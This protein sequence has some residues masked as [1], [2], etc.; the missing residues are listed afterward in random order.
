ML[1]HRFYYSFDK[2]SFSFPNTIYSPT[3]LTGLSVYTKMFY[4]VEP[5]SHNSSQGTFMLSCKSSA[6][7]S[8]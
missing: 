4:G 6:H 5:K 1:F 3:V 2:V 8:K 7:Q